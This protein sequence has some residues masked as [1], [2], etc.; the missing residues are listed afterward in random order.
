MKDERKYIPI[1]EPFVGKEEAQIVRE[2]LASGWLT[3]GPR[4]K[5]FEEAF[6]V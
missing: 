5:D 3:Q 2:T 1:A 4:V 6:A